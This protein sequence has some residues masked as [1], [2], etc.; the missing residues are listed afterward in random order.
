M[1]VPNKRL[2]LPLYEESGIDLK[3]KRKKRKAK[4]TKEKNNQSRRKMQSLAFSP[5]C[6][7]SYI[8]IA[9]NGR[10]GAARIYTDLNYTS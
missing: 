10:K 5:Y 3:R 8:G 7:F 9:A 2:F 4:L 6:P 1:E